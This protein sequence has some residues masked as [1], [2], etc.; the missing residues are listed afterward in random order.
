MSV[1]IAA[2]VVWENVGLDVSTSFFPR[3]DIKFLQCVNKFLGEFGYTGEVNL[4]L[5]ELSQLVDEEDERVTQESSLKDLDDIQCHSFVS[6]GKVHI[7]HSG[8]LL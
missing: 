1:Q 3:L 6:G 8:T 5:L 7:I 2:L 4:L